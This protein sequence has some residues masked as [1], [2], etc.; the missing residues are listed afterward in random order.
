[1]AADGG[2]LA[3]R[4]Q[5][6]EPYATGGFRI[7]HGGCVP[8]AGSRT[9]G[10]AGTSPGPASD[11]SMGT[12]PDCAFGSSLDAPP[13]SRLDTPFDT[14]FDTVELAACLDRDGLSLLLAFLSAGPGRPGEGGPA[15]QDLDE[16]V[17]LIRR[18]HVPYYEPARD[19]F[20]DPAVR[21]ALRRGDRVGPYQSPELRRLAAGEAGPAAPR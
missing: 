6:Q 2:V 10:P 18:L 17:D 7:L 11:S 15:V 3:F 8:P 20:D 12:S 1:M 5:A 9:G 13:D 19:R 21:E 4:T 16:F 14:P